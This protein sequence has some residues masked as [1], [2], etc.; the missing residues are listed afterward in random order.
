MSR[1]REQNNSHHTAHTT[2]LKALTSTVQSSY[3]SIGDYLST[4]FERVQSLESDMNAQANA[5]KE[6]LPALAEN[7][8]IRAPLQELRDT[9]GSQ[10]LIE[11]NPTG[12]TPQRAVYSVPEKLPRTG[13]HEIILSR[14]RDGPPSADNRSPSKGII[15]NDATESACSEDVFAPVLKPNFSR[16]NSTQATSIP[17]GT[18]LRELDVNVVAQETHTQPLPVVSNS[19]TVV[20]AAPPLKKQCSEDN[21]KAPMRK[22]RKTVGGEGKGDR[23]NLTITNFSSSI[24]PGLGRRLRSHGSS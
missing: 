24:G 11:Y 1:V 7:A 23:E 18:S 20:V 10:H 16:S 9:I 13:A 15:F 21:T 3:S 4:S 8:S 19:D 2:S 22:M 5:L 14:L 17:L 6:T 12:E